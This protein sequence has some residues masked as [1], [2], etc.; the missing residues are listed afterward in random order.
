MTLP[1]GAV[2]YGTPDED[3]VRFLARTLIIFENMKKGVYDEPTAEASEA[4]M[5]EARAQL[6][7]GTN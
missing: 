7:G 1:S 3:G 6:R 5:D 4:K 2:Y